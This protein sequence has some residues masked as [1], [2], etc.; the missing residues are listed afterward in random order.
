MTGTY[1]GYGFGRRDERRDH[2]AARAMTAFPGGEPPPESP[3]PPRD[4]SIY[5]HVEDMVGDE[6]ELEE[7]AEEQR[8][9]EQHRRL[10]EIQTELDQIW[11]TLRERAEQRGRKG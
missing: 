10:R 1:H 2:Q 8:T 7:I 6:Y 5:T 3:E 4:T 9:A 11:H